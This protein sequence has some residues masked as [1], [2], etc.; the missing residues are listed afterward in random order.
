MKIIACAVAAA[1]LATVP[2]AAQTPKPSTLPAYVGTWALDSSQCTLTQDDEN[3]PLVMRADGYQQQTE[4]CSFSSVKPVKK[5]WA[6]KG[7]CSIDGKKEPLSVTLSI[8]NDELNIDDG[9]GVR[10]LKRCR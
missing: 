4:T 5:N 1:A 3:A 2:A 7:S 9:S 8:V 10:E 6:V